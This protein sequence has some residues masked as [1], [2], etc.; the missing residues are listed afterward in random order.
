MT[1]KEEGKNSQD[2][3][4]EIEMWNKEIIFIEEEMKM[5]KGMSFTVEHTQLRK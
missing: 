4:H 2:A 1:K 5:K 3:A